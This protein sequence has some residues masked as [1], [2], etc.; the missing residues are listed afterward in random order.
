MSPTSSRRRRPAALPKSAFPANA[1]AKIC[2]A[3]IARL[4]RGEAPVTPKFVNTCYSIAA[5]DYGFSIAGVYPPVDGQWLAVEGAG[6]ISPLD[7]PPEFRRRE[8][9][10]AHSWF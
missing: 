8:A 1:A 6:G 2:A 3:A 7:A 10:L 9:E 5:P 4:V